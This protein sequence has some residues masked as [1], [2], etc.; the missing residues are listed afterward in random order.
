MDAKREIRNVV[1]EL[2]YREATPEQTEKGQLGTIRGRAIVFNSESGVLDERGEQFREVVTPE[3]VT[4]SF[5]KTQDIKVNMLHKRDLTFGRWMKGQS[6][7]TRLFVEDEGLGFEVDVPDCDLGIRA[8]ALTMAGVF[9]GCSFEFIPELYDVKRSKGDL[10]I[11]YHR[12]FKKI[13]AITLGMDPAYQATTL[14]ARELASEEED[15]DTKR[16]CGDDDEKKRTEDMPD[17]DADKTD[18]TDKADDETKEDGDKE[19]VEREYQYRKRKI[20]L[21]TNPLNV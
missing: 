15:E 3:A 5:L 10:P 12:K 21:L 8:R 14:S 16:A 6:G 2:S 7:N 17:D 13:E 18:D 20:R 9:T 1:C 19:A 4:E 11:V